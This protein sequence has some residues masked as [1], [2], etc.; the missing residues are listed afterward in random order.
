MATHIL[1]KD[2]PEVPERTMREDMFIVDGWEVTQNLFSFCMLLRRQRAFRNAKFA[3]ERT[4]WGECAELCMYFPNQLYILGKVSY[5][6]YNIGMQTDIKMSY[7]VDSRKVRNMK[8]KKEAHQRRA[9]SVN[10]DRAVNNA[11]KYLIPY[12]T[13]DIAAASNESASS[14]MARVERTNRW[15]K[16]GAEEALAEDIKS[17]KSKVM[18]ELRHLYENGHEFVTEGLRSMV[19][20][21]LDKTQISQE[22]RTATY[23]CTLLHTIAPQY[24]GAP[25]Q[26]CLVRGGVVQLNG[27]VIGN[28]TNIFNNAGY[29]S[30]A[31]Q[32]LPVAEV[33]E[34]IAGKAMLLSMVE[35]RSFVEGVGYR[36]TAD[37][38]YLLHE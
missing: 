14:Q 34:D 20:D 4:S 11:K 36:L 8:Y 26:V 5:A 19:A 12:T 17:S 38:M 33:P 30:S 21:A 7:C 31:T 22:S 1:V 13:A 6:D 28:M 16:E 27:N 10:L 24:E 37:I 2:L 29:V 35:D 9:L 32:V 3:P 18:N 25:P 23:Q 15:S